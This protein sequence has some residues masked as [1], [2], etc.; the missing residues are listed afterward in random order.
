MVFAVTA[1]IAFSTAQRRNQ[2]LNSIQNYMALH[3]ERFGPTDVR[4]VA[5]DFGPNSIALDV[6]FLDKT[7]ANE[8]ISSFSTLTQIV[9]GYYESHDCPHDSVDPDPCVG[10][11]RV[12]L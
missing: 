11:V 3:P 2:A 4:A 8:L 1:E 10:A 5:T 12:T 9:G 7:T 6:R